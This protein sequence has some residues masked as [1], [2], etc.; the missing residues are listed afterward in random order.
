MIDWTSGLQFLWK[1]RQAVNT[2]H[3]LTVP[4]SLPAIFLSDPYATKLLAA[5]SVAMAAVQFGM[6]KFTQQQGMKLI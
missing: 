3:Y 4:L 5:T 1:S 2:W 6:T